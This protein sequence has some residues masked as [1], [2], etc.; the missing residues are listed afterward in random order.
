[1]NQNIKPSSQDDVIK[2][3]RSIPSGITFVHG[4]AGCGKTHLIKKLVSEIS[5]CQVLVPTNLAA[6]LYNGARTLHSFFYGAFDSLDEG[7]Q[8]PQNLSPEKVAGIRGV[9]SSIRLLVIDEISMV[10]SD[11]FEMMHQICQM[12]LGNGQPFGGIPIVLV[13]DMFQLPPIISDDAVLEYLKNEYGGVYFFN[14]HII[15]AEL[16]KIK[17]FEL[18]K[19]YRHENDSSFVSILDSFRQPMSPQKKVEIMNVLNSRVTTPLPSDAIYIAS[20][21]EEVRQVNTQKLSELPGTITTLDAEYTIQKKDGSGY[22]VIKHGQLPC[23]EDIFDIIVPSAYD[24]QLSFKKGARVVLCKSSKYW[25][26]VN[27]DFGIIENFNDDYFTIKLDTGRI[28]QCPNPNDRYK[29]QQKT[30]YR[31]EMVYDPAK[32]HLVRKTPFIQKTTQYPI[33][34]AYAFTIHKAQGQTYEKVIV[35]LNSHIF[36]PGQLYVALSRAKSLQGLFL[37]KPITYSDIISDESV[38]DFLNKIRGFNGISVLSTQNVGN[39]ALNSLSYNFS[40]FVSNHEKSPSSKEYI[41]HS[42]NCFD[43]L[44]QFEEYEKAYGELQKV[45]DLIASTYEV[46][47]YL[48]MLETIRTPNFSVSGC[49]LALTAIYE[50]YTDVVKLPRKQYQSENRTNI[51]DLSQYN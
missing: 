26:Y 3:L 51:L 11:L 42:L 48:K 46:E 22:V 32:H 1:M 30:E 2:Y 9:L 35:D 10:R 50:I 20:S 6:S 25:G 5:G 21:N 47:N 23:E 28:I 38:F 14:S 44:I 41:I 18:T 24:A 4:K 33:K 31:Y 15:Q 45:I 8:N 39:K 37:T 27:G 29:S 43:T 49:K 36:A 34:L 13:G 16:Q 12:A 40:Y 7:Y 19:S 17:L